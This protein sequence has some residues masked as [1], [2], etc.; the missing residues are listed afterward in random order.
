MTLALLAQRELQEYLYSAVFSQKSIEG[1]QCRCEGLTA[2]IGSACCLTTS[3]HV[4]ITPPAPPGSSL[5]GTYPNT[6]GIQ[7]MANESQTSR[8]LMGKLHK[9]FNMT[10]MTHVNISCLCHPLCTSYSALS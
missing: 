7:N 2:I 10:L 4:A 6:P 5:A 3:L 9:S 1:L 8:Y